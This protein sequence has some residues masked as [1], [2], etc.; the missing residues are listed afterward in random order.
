MIAGAAGIGKGEHQVWAEFLWREMQA[1]L[2]KIIQKKFTR[3]ACDGLLP[4]STCF[5]FALMP[6]HRPATK[7]LSGKARK[8]ERPPLFCTKNHGKHG[9][10]VNV[11]KIM[12]TTLGVVLS[13]PPLGVVIFVHFGPVRDTQL[14]C[15]RARIVGVIPLF[16]YKKTCKIVWPAKN[17]KTLGKV[18]Q[19]ILRARLKYGSDPEQNPSAKS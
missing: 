6:D 9:G 4:K 3:S 2:V 8:V 10:R 12:A 18:W 7:K 17:K 13:C 14:F 5:D 11:K 1:N 19:R 16:L 15:G